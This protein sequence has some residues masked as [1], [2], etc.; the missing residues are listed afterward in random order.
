M[1]RPL[2]VVQKGFVR[3]VRQKAGQPQH[4][5]GRCAVETVAASER[6]L[7]HLFVTDF[8]L[9]VV[10]EYEVDVGDHFCQKL[11]FFAKKVEKK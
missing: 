11:L 3:V 1:Q 4:L 8:G 5:E 6:A 7:R 10:A 9:G 2:E